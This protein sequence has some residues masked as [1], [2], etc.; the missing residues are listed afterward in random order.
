MSR[1]VGK[2]LKFHEWKHFE[3]NSVACCSIPKNSN[4]HHTLL[5]AWHPHILSIFDSVLRLIVAFGTT[6]PVKFWWLLETNFWQLVLIRQQKA[7][8]SRDQSHWDLESNVLTARPCCLPKM[9]VKSGLQP[10]SRIILSQMFSQILMV[11]WRES[12][13][14]SR[15][16]F[17]QQNF[18]GFV[19]QIKMCCSRG[20]RRGLIF[21]ER[22][23]IDCN[24]S[25]VDSAWICLWICQQRHEKFKI[26]SKIC[27]EV[28]LNG[29][30]S[31]SFY[32]CWLSFTRHSPFYIQG[33]SLLLSDGRVGLG[34]P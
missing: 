6:N 31:L 11:A 29:N 21:F 19:M 10:G 22:C 26:S 2:C 9:L 13:F 30:W 28:T 18:A 27:R 7:W 16:K 25:G 1:A 17:T 8:N 4:T 34:N 14:W 3:S 24:T 12:R 5:G 20:P 15:W 23:H 33:A 32:A